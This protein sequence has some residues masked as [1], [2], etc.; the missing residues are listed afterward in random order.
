VSRTIEDRQLSLGQSCTAHDKHMQKCF[1]RCIIRF[2]WIFV[3]G[4][5]PCKRFSL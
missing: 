2:C 1:Y 5:S 4:K 3:W